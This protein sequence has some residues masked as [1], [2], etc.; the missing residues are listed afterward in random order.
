MDIEYNKKQQ[1]P[2][3][4]PQE[5]PGNDKKS[6]DLKDQS[7]LPHQQNRLKDQENSRR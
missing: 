6:D 1:N 5:N 3:G 2:I 7:R 4:Y